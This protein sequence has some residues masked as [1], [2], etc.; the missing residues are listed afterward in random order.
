MGRVPI[1]PIMPHADKI[2][3]LESVTGLMQ[4]GRVKLPD[5]APWIADY[6]GELTTFPLAAHDDQVD[7]TSQAL[8]WMRDN[9]GRHYAIAGGRSY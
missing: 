4:S 2:D 8:T 9:S 5:A 7:S 1:I 6:L 3:R